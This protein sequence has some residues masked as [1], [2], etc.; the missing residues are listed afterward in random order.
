MTVTTGSLRAWGAAA[1]GLS[2]VAVG[3]GNP[4][5]GEP[6]AAAPA[7]DATI[8]EDAQ[9]EQL[10]SAAELS[11]VNVLQTTNTRSWRLSGSEDMSGLTDGD[12]DVEGFDDWRSGGAENRVDPNWVAYYFE[13]P[14]PV[15]GAALYE[16]VEADNVGA[17]TFQWRNMRGGWEDTSVGTLTNEDDRLALTAEFDVVT[18]TGFRAVFENKSDSSWMRLAELEVWGPEQ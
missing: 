13:R 3:L 9:T 7:D 16:P 4:A 11:G 14:T 8:A 17:V 1:F 18:A 12:R 5:G 15:D 2:L 10:E 6:A